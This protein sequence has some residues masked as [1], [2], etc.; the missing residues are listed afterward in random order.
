M[1]IKRLFLGMEIHAPWPEELPNGRLLDPENRHLTL[2][3][4]GNVD[5]PQ[6]QEALHTFPS[7]LF[8]LGFA[9]T[10]DQCLFLPRPHPHVV[11]WHVLWGVREEMFM[12]YQKTLIQWLQKKGFSTDPKEQFMPHVTLCRAP[13]KEQSWQ[14]V[15][16]PLPLIAHHIHLYESVGNL[17]Y[18]S[19]WK[20][21]MLAPFEE[22]EHTADLAYLIRGSTYNELFYHAAIALCFHFPPLVTFISLLNVLNLEEVI[23]A[24]NQLVYKADCEIGCPFKAVSFHS[25]MQNEKN[26]LQWMMIIDV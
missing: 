3:F 5:Y 21:S 7:P 1:N 12:A 4:L 15:F 19:L 24:L 13:F 20:Y 11:A 9:A 25:Q 17:K 2:A 22:I 26:I 10:F 18:K 23:I 14:R 8:T 6:I 16:K